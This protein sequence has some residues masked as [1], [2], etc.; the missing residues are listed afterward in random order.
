M[1][2]IKSGSANNVL[3]VDSASKAARVTLYDTGGLA[4]S[5]AYSIFM[6]PIHC[7]P[8]GTLSNGQTY[9]SMRNTGTKTVFLRGMTLNLSFA[10]ASATVTATRSHY[11][12][13]RFATATPTAGTAVTVVKRR[14]SDPA[15]SVGDVRFLATGLTTTGAT[16]E[17]ASLI[18]AINNV[19][20]STTV[21]GGHICVTQQIDLTNGG[22]E[23]RIV[24]AP[25]EGFCIRANSTWGLPSVGSAIIGSIWWDERA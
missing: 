24:L 8:S 23:G 4:L 7:V 6:A 22:E 2:V 5:P 18:V 25:G 10:T 17:T 13:C 3:D 14:N 9:W 19:N 20:A 1:A 12:F 21:V 11:E 16:F 15:T